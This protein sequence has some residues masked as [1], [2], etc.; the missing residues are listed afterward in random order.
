MNVCEVFFDVVNFWIDK[1]VEG[2]CLDVLNVIVKFKFLEDDFEG[3]GCCFYIDG[4]G[5]YV[6]LKELYE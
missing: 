6:Y 4:L 2:F 1:G 3:D 5:I